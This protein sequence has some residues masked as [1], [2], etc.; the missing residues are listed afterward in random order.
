MNSLIE[1]LND[2][3]KVAAVQKCFGI[4]LASETL[5]N[6]K[7]DDERYD[8]KWATSILPDHENACY[9]GRKKS[10]E[11]YR[12]FVR[13]RFF[14]YFFQFITRM[15]NEIFYILFLPIMTWN[16]D[17]RMLSFITIT[18]ALVMYVGQ[19]TKDIIKMPRP[20]TPPVV[21]IE[22]QYLLEYGFPSTH[23]MAAMTISFTMMHQI[24][25]HSPSMELEH[26]LTIFAICFTIG[27]L[28]CLSRLYLGMHS[29]LD[30]SAGLLY[31]LALSAL[32]TSRA[33]WLVDSLCSSLPFGVLVYLFFLLAC[34]VYPSR[35][36]WS[37]ARADT[38]LI[39]GVGAGIG[40][41][42]ALKN[43]LG[44]H[45]IGKISELT[46]LTDNVTLSLLVSRA[47]VGTI[48]VLIARYAS[49][50]IVYSLTRLVYRLPKSSD[51]DLK[52]FIKQKFFLELFYYFFTYSNVSFTVIF[53]S[54]VALDY[55]NLK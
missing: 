4:E 6:A 23:A 16:Y 8:P 46:Y 28:V 15:G 12:Y 34:V 26:R 1:Y 10:D 33:K 53:M 55:F 2:P 13:S 52:E 44:L 14:Y 27:S 18:W 41:G 22:E 35:K 30:L 9:T 49:K 39:Q 36:R 25:T 38:F 45:G 48:G 5:I 54:F 11:R 29:L 31:S 24:F 17:D 43:H 50:K 37:S 32:M 47:L 7:R 20:H 3:E 51:N 42:M 21:K 40:L 19:A